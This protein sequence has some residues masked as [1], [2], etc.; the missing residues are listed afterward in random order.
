MCRSIAP[1]IADRDIV[2][3]HF[4]SGLGHIQRANAVTNERLPWHRFIYRY[5]NRYSPKTLSWGLQLVQGINFASIPPHCLN[6]L[7]SRGSRSPSQVARWVW[8]RSSSDATVLGWIK[9]LSG[10]RLITSQGTNAPNCA[11][12]KR[13]TSNMAT[14]WGPIGR[15]QKRYIL[16]SGTALVS[17]DQLKL[18]EMYGYVGNIHTFSADSLPECFCIFDLVGVVLIKLLVHISWREVSSPTWKW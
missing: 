18:V 11:G 3:S 13:F 14:G 5:A 6:T 7:V 10:P 12:V 16:S 2:S 9:A 17:G 8:L 1:N 4:L 15:S